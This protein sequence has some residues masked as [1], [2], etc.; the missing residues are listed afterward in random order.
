M[1]R[2]QERIWLW[3]RCWSWSEFYVSYYEKGRFVDAERDHVVVGSIWVAC[4]NYKIIQ[5]SGN[6]GSIFLQGFP[7][8][9]NDGQLINLLHRFQIIVYF[10]F[11]FSRK[12]VDLKKN[13]NNVS[14]SIG[15]NKYIIKV[16]FMKNFIKQISY[17]KCWQIFA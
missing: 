15:L 14:T 3:A 7:Y 6:V 5:K 12:F 16:H 13:R 8:V 4:I 17:R 10:S 9:I 1:N 11:V 2:Q